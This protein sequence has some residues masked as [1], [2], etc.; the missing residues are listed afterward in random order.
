[1][2]KKTAVILAIVLAFSMIL[3]GCNDKEK[4]AE[5]VTDLKTPAQNSPQT[6]AAPATP[7]NITYNSS[8]LAISFEHPENWNV[9]ENGNMVFVSSPPASDSMIV[10]ADITY[11]VELFLAG[12]GDLENSVE[13]LVDKYQ[14]L[15]TQNST[16]TS[17]EYNWDQSGGGNIQAKANFTY[18]T[19]AGIYKGLVDVEQLGGRVFLSITVG[20]NDG[21]ADELAE[22]YGHLN[23]T[24][25]AQY[26]D[27]QLQPADLSDLGFPEPPRGFERFYSPVSGQYFIF[28]SDWTLVS[29]PHDSTVILVNDRG[30]LM[31]TTNWTET[32]FE[33]YNSN[34]NDLEDCFDEFLLECAEA[35]EMIYGEV[36]RYHDFAPM[37]T[38]NQELIKATFN[39][40]VSSGTGRAFAELGYRES[41]GQEF[42]QATLCL[43]KAGDSYSIDMFSIIMDSTHILFPEL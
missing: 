33:H 3:A 19:T 6:P 41:G 22:V 42:V 16:L 40:T 35:L 37:R 38:E 21:R 39:Y 36:P 18:T 25:V 23:A 13:A 10:I 29:N 7:V 43:Y 26:T 28:P 4:P 15:V 24:F 1:M 8:G 32:F 20:P 14:S 11:E 31:L 17:Y 9:E 30:A 34:G 2:Y 12:H 27:R 5:P